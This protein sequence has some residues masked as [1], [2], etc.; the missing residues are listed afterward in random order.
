MIILDP[1]IKKELEE[2]MKEWEREVL[3]NQIEIE[4]QEINKLYSQ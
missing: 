4:V 3:N 2:E 1:K